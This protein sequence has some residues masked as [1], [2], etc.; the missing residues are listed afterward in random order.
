MPQVVPIAWLK[1]DQTVPIGQLVLS[2]DSGQGA[3][4]AFRYDKEWLSSGFPLG[5]DLPLSPTILYPLTDSMETD[6]VLAARSD[7]FGFFADH[8][9][10]KWVE[11][12]IRQAHLN[13]LKIDF[14]EGA[15]AS[16]EIW[17]RSGHV[18]GRFSALSLPLTHG[19][20][21]KFLPPVLEIEGFGKNSKSV[22]N[23]GLAMQALNAGASIRGKELVEMLLSSAME[24]GGT[25]PKCVVRLGKSDDEWVVR[26]ASAR[27]PVNSALWMAVTR[28]LAQACGI[29][30]VEGKLIAPRLYAER[31]F[32]RAE[33][34]SPLLCLSAATLVRR[35]MTRERILH[36]TPKTYLDIADI[37]NRCGADPTAD[38]RALF[39]RLLFNT[40]TGNNRDRLDQFW[41]TPTEMG[42]KLLPM[43]APCAQ[44]P[45]LSARFLS[46]PLK[47]GANVA[48]PETAIVLSRYFGVS[49][50][51]AKAMRLEFMQVLSEWRRIAET[52]GADLLEIRQMQGAF[53]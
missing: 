33:D 21:T 4:M 1:K 5:S 24:L 10:G 12:L 48:D 25:N 34:G 42:W 16:T 29:K 37:L 47:P 30:V 50:K 15:P 49:I 6:P 46:T 22:K 13:D 39:A 38:L 17:T 51:D 3:S 44:L 7:V 8:A 18:F 23:L 45:F 19:F 11:K 14:L 2:D 27:E 9:P 26:Y 41:F 43:Y 32:D 28:E 31:R 35:Q 36:P 40:L 20:H 52:A 53:G